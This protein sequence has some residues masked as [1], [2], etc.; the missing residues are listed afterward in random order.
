MLE[1]CVGTLGTIFLNEVLGVWNNTQGIV[2]TTCEYLYDNNTETEYICLD[3]NYALDQVFWCHI[4]TAAQFEKLGHCKNEQ[5]V[6]QKKAQL[7]VTPH[8]FQ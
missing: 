5:E 2:S 1:R 6:L 8:N 3:G 4:S 7:T